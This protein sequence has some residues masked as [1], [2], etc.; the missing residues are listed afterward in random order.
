M[1]STVIE[2]L[3]SGVEVASGGTRTRIK[4]DRPWQ[5]DIVIDRKSCPFERREQKIVKCIADNGGWLVIENPATPF[6]FHRL[7][8]PQKCWR[9][10]QLR[11][12]GGTTQI[13]V[14]LRLGW[15]AASEVGG[16]IWFFVHIGPTAGQNIGHLHYHVVQPLQ[17]WSGGRQDL[18]IPKPATAKRRTL[19]GGTDFTVVTGGLRAGQCL[20]YPKGRKPTLNRPPLLNLAETVTRI[21]DLYSLKFRSTQGLPPDFILAFTF[22]DGML[23]YGTYIPILNQWGATEYVG[24]M[25]GHPLILAW[26][27]D[28]SATHLAGE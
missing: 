8:L 15:S 25:E 3:W 4:L 5:T 19:F 2:R 20:I 10:Q 6:A 13:S 9:S 12:L 27:H 17:H 24:L 28:K 21:I 16:K 11:A 1:T 23:C 7:I 26:P 14:A 22:N 18:R